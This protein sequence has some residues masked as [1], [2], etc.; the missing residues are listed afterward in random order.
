[1]KL[2]QSTILTSWISNSEG[3]ILSQFYFSTKNKRLLHHAAKLCRIFT[4]KAFPQVT[5]H[6]HQRKHGTMGTGFDMQSGNIKGRL[7]RYRSG[8]RK[9]C[10]ILLL[11]N[12]YR[13][14]LD[15]VGRQQCCQT[16]KHIICGRKLIHDRNMRDLLE[17]ETTRRL[18]FYSSTSRQRR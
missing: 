3:N 12:L 8:M 18:R 17:T 4:A 2:L 16:E 14:A 15:Q 6:A 9:R 1:L 10:Q 11:Y 7:R 13:V 5:L